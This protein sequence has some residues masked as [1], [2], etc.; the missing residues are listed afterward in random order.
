MKQCVMTGR[1][2]CMK[3]VFLTSRMNQIGFVPKVATTASEE[4]LKVYLKRKIEREDQAAT[5]I[6]KLRHLGLGTP[7]ATRAQP[8]TPATSAKTSSSRSEVEAFHLSVC[9]DCSGISS[10]AKKK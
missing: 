6:H 2:S 1:H 3:L 10:I 9:S 4:V 8:R 7:S 5:V